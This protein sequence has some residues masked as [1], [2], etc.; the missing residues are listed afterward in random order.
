[1]ARRRVKAKA[2]P[3]DTWD[4][5]RKSYDVRLDA[6]RYFRIVRPH[7]LFKAIEEAAEVHN[8]AVSAYVFGLPDAS[9]AMTLRCLEVGLGHR[10][11]EVEKTGAPDD[12]FSLI[13]WS[14]QY[15][16]KKKEIAHGFRLLRN[17]IHG[18]TLIKEQ[19]AIEAIRHTTDIL[20]I[21]YPFET[22]SVDFP[23]NLCSATNSVQ[24]AKEQCFLGNRLEVTRLCSNCQ[25]ETKTRLVVS[26]PLP[27]RKDEGDAQ[28]GA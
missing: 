5:V 9:V 14:E 15:L 28:P 13:D 24:I 23:C 6:L 11:E 20:N 10:Y 7:G 19:D 25:K 4:D 2:A 16:G 22:V 26:P 21:L 27:T 1:M 3:A 12:L 18:E 17:L 8:Q